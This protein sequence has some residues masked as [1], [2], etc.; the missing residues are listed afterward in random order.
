MSDRQL[1]ID[2]LALLCQ[3]LP[4]QRYKSEQRVIDAL[5]ERIAEIEQENED[6]RPDATNNRPALFP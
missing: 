5:R 4:N 6:A 1:L 2:A 3:L